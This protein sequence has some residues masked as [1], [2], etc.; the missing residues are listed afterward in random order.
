[1]R[2]LQHTH[3]G[4]NLIEYSLIVAIVSAALAAMTTYVFRAMQTKQQEVIRA[5]NE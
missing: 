1:M 3:K 4:Q 2:L 5:A